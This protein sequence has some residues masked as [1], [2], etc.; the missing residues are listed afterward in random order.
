MPDVDGAFFRDERGVSVIFGTLMLILVIIVGISGLAVMVT[1]A[2]KDMMERETHQA[3]VENEK[4]KFVSIEPSVDSDPL[5][6]LNVTLLNLNTADSRLS[7]ISVNGQFAQNY[8]LMDDSG[9]LV[10]CRGY[11]GIYPQVYGHTVRV[12]VPATRSRTLHLNFSDITI[13]S[14]E[15]FE[16][17]GWEDGS[18]DYTY[19]LSLHPGKAYRDPEYTVEVCN[20]TD[21][22]AGGTGKDYLMDS[23]SGK[24]TL[25]SGGK[26]NPWLSETINVSSWSN[27]SA[28]YTVF[29]PEAP[30][31]SGSENVSNSTAVFSKNSD[32]LINPS[33][34]ELTLISSDFGGN[35]TNSGGNYKISYKKAGTSYN[36]DYTTVFETFPQ[37]MEV[38]MSE[39][40]NLEIISSLINIF[41]QTFMPPVPIAE[42]QFETERLEDSNGTAIYRDYLLLDASN[43]FDPDGFITDYKWAV[44]DN[45]TLVYDYNLTGLKVRPTKLVLTSARNV[46]IDLQV[47]DDSGMSS[48]LSQTA[49][50]ISVL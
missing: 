13:N 8:L 32:Y 47:K 37:P 3:A 19:S 11:E 33:T 15:S 49:G 50:Y 4:I 20:A 41:K 35:M 6:Y 26:M 21:V 31:V 22:F 39:P 24:I 30:L 9:E 34:G 14:N 43:S 44:W 25:L 5:D 18:L 40:I 17:S 48:R 28:N 46:R 27:V 42:V 2:Q 23:E 10:Y 16:L 36:I 45:G 38:S 7:A 12:P 1:T 29:L